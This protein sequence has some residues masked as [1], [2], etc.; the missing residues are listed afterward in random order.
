MLGVTDHPA[1]VAYHEINLPDDFIV[2][3]HHY[4]PNVYYSSAPRSDVHCVYC[5]CCSVEISHSVEP[6]VY[7]LRCLVLYFEMIN[8]FELR[9]R[10][11]PVWNF[12]TNIFHKILYIWVGY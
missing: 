2:Q 11:L 10:N 8:I 3:F 1:N 12:T 9:F 5:Y 7:V 4:I 6:N